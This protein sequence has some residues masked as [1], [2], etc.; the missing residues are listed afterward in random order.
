LSQTIDD[1][2]TAVRELP[3]QFFA[4]LP[5]AIIRYWLDGKYAGGLAPSV[6]YEELGWALMVRGFYRY[7]VEVSNGGQLKLSHRG[8]SV[9]D[10]QDGDIVCK[11]IRVK[12]NDPWKKYLGWE[13]PFLWKSD[14]SAIRS[15]PGERSARL[16]CALRLLATDKWKGTSGIATA[17]KNLWSG[18]GGPNK[19]APDQDDDVERKE[20]SI[21]IP[22][23][24]RR[25][26][27]DWHKIKKE[28]SEI[29]L[30]LLKAQEEELNR[31]D[32]ELKRQKEEL[33]TQE[34]V[35]AIKETFPEMS[36][37]VSKLRA[38]I[39]EMI[40]KINNIEDEIRKVTAKLVEQ[41]VAGVPD[42]AGDF[43]GFMVNIQVPVGNDPVVLKGT[44][45]TFGSPPV[46][47]RVTFTRIENFIA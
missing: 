46:S 19:E 43:S 29:K 32:A 27:E 28:I 44:Y 4:P 9:I 17:F 39:P 18:G 41:N 34:E 42:F 16:T 10:L 1:L 15:N 33:K 13:Y 22:Y 8:Y 37:E 14:V 6:A 3:R 25:L 45:S 35:I 31:K 23:M 5:T 24:A 40:L 21:A 11:G 36:A 20:Q 38:A 26:D 2:I 30:R 7:K 12:S 47:G